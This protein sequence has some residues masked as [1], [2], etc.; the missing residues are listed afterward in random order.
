MK[1]KVI[2]TGGCGYIGSHTTIRLLEKGFQVVLLDDLSNTYPESLDRIASISGKKP[3]LEVI[4]LKDEKA[5]KRCFEKHLD[6]KSVIHF[7]A[8]KAVG[9]SVLHPLKYYNNNLKAL[10][11]V[12]LAMESQKISTILFSSSATVYGHPQIVPISEDCPT[13]RPFSSYGN[14]KKIGEEILEDWALS[15]GFRALSLRYFN[16]IGA[17]PSGRIG[18]LPQGTPNNLL[19]F[20]TQV[21]TGKLK[22]LQVFGDDYDTKDGTAVRDYIHVM[23]LADAHVLALEHLMGQSGQSYF[24][25]FNLGTGKGYTVM[26]IIQNFEKVSGT[27][28]NYQ[29]GD[30]RKGDVPVLFADSKKAERVLGWK[31]KRELEEMISDA[32]RWEQRQKQ[33][34]P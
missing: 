11:N 23:D 29:I 34:N 31:A 12:M 21:A 13:N 20:I 27:S 7:A 28:L 22:R 25:A 16:P 19:P 14:S 15:S 26:E 8:H 2:V 9:E 18:E 5:T 6:A 17:H 32:W 10:L 24:E 33:E 1:N 3:V 4:D 30:R